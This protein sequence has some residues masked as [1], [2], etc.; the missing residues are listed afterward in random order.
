MLLLFISKSNIYLD[1]STFVFY[2]GNISTAFYY[3]S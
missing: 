3:I 2:S 1:V